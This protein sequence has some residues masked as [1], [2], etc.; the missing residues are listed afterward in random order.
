MKIFQT[1]KFKKLK[2]NRKGASLDNFWVAISFFGLAIFFIAIMLF[3]NAVN[4]MDIFSQSSVGPQIQ[5]NAQNA[6]NQFD[7]MILMAYFGLHLGILVFAYLL[8]THPVVYVAG[9]ILVA[10]LALI[11]APLS[12]AYEDIKEDT[13]ISTVS[14]DIPRT[15]HILSNLP[16]YE[17][18]WGIVTLVVMFGFAR[19][20]GFV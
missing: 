3:W 10:F 8:R 5:N 15:N 19:M 18:I 6:V 13:E 4:G 11:A 16:K 7:F 14:G 12:N 2:K 20:E 17:I 1:K 9:I